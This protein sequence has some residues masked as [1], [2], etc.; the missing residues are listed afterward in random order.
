MV[1]TL[2]VYLRVCVRAK[3]LQ[4]CPTLCDPMDC[5]LPVYSVHGILQAGILKWVVMPC[6]PT[7]ASNPRLLHFLHWQAGS[8]LCCSF[9]GGSD[10]KAS[11]CNAGDLGLISGS[12]RSL[13]ERNGNTLQNSCLENHMNRG[14]W[15]AAVHGVAKC[16]TQLSDF[17][18]FL[19]ECPLGSPT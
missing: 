15:R 1:V 12:G 7:Q 17:T 8:L 18:F 9:P 3:L 11:A 19:Y 4:S 16:W 14:A 5:S 2:R 13:G 10:S 6:F